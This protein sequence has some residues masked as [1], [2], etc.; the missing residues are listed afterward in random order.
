MRQAQSRFIILIIHLLNFS[1]GCANGVDSEMVLAARLDEIMDMHDGRIV[2]FIKIDVEG[3]EA[4]VFE[5]AKVTIKSM[6]PVI[7]FEVAHSVIYG[8]VLSHLRPIDF[9]LKSAICFINT[10]TMGNSFHARRP[11]KAIYLQCTESTRYV[12]ILC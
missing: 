4:I 11:K 6:K 7:M 12:I 1:L 2:S 5:S 9:C 10:A 3:Y 8:P